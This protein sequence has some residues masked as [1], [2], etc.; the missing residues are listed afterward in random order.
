MSDF[1]QIKNILHGFNLEDDY[2]INPDATENTG[3]VI[4]NPSDANILIKAGA[5]IKPQLTKMR[6]AV[7]KIYKGYL[8]AYDKESYKKKFD[9]YPLR[10]FETYMA[11]LGAK[12]ANNG[13][14]FEP[15]GEKIDW[16]KLVRKEIKTRLADYNKNE[17][18]RKAELEQKKVDEEATK[19]SENL[20]KTDNNN[21]K[22]DA[23]I[24]RETLKRDMGI[25]VPKELTDLDVINLYNVTKEGKY[26]PYTE[27]YKNKLPKGA[28][29]K[30]VDYL[31]THPIPLKSTDSDISN[32][33][34]YVN[35]NRERL[36]QLK[37]G[38]SSY[39]KQY[40]EDL[41]RKKERLDS[42]DDANAK[43]IEIL[44]KEIRDL[45]AKIKESENQRSSLYKGII[46]SESD[47]DDFIDTLKTSYERKISKYDGFTTQGPFCLEKRKYF[48]EVY[49]PSI[50]HID[51]EFREP[52]KTTKTAKDEGNNILAISHKKGVL[53][54]NVTVN[55]ETGATTEKIN[56]QTIVK[57]KDGKEFNLD[58]INKNRT[59]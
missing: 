37:V 45:E 43:E 46:Q 40:K 25:L 31:R 52:L 51:T 38:T 6:S 36:S 54:P 58:R 19:I 21:I 53:D 33:T 8:A 47:H 12:R 50:D 23:N 9:I 39:V 14:D 5:T 22:N 24:I 2:F 56:D 1:D 29:D 3:E 27:A 41:K 20:N 10:D 42:L 16:I 18:K 59:N 30:L 28:F 55:P 13:K 26:Y 44:N 4:S 17:E 34:D 11:D 35:K 15:V 32:E 48:L 49:R 7:D 57:T